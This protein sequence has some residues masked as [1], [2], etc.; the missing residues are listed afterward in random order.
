M[1]RG[2]SSRIG[3]FT[4]IQWHPG[5]IDRGNVFPNMIGKQPKRN[6]RVWLQD[7]SEGLGN[8]HGSGPLQSI[9]MANSLC[10]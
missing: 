5:E 4:S 10:L 7:G 1:W 3:N 6:V 9:Q 2:G 8:N